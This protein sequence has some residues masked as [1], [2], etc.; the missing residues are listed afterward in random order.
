[1]NRFKTS[2][3]QATVQ[4][5]LRGNQ[6]KRC[7]CSAPSMREEECSPTLLH[8]THP[9]CLRPSKLSFV[10]SFD[11]PFELDFGVLGIVMF[12]KLCHVEDLGLAYGTID[13]DFG[14]MIFPGIG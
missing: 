2:K 12:N 7:H 8:S 3:V 6:A 9:L 5:S 11:I 10:S 1:M 14:S 4:L 13:G